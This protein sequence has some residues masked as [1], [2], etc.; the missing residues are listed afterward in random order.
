MSFD[1][2]EDGEDIKVE[3]KKRLAE[4]ES[5]LS[6]QERADIMEASQELFERCIAIVKK[7]D[8]EVRR[9]QILSQLLPVA[10]VIAVVLFALAYYRLRR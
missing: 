7:L 2:D 8:V 6:A 5:L 10:V 4:G 9:Q 3:Y 1:G